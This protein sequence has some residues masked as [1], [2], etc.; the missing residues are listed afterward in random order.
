M[1]YSQKFCVA[2]KSNGKV[3]REFKDSVYIPFGSE[4][5]IYLKNLNAVRAVAKISIDGTDVCSTDF[6]VNP[7]SE[8]DIERFVKDNLKKGNRFKFIER[9]SQIEKHRGIETEDGLI[10][11]A[12]KFEKIIPSPVWF[13]PPYI[14]NGPWY[15]NAVGRYNNTNDSTGTYS[16]PTGTLRGVSQNA[17]VSQVT[18]SVNN[19]VGITVPGS[20][21]NQTFQTVSS[22]AMEDEEHIIIIRLL[23]EIETGKEVT[24]PVTVKAKATCVTCG[25]K[26]KATSSFCSECGTALSIL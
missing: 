1:M 11:V 16:A 17:H 20:V 19:D 8:I 14:W 13:G 23:G 4:Y 15:T 12:F 21:S 6:V 2:V 22:F 5:S 7:N 18:A 10:R 24:Q 9:T 25:K 3:L 26:N